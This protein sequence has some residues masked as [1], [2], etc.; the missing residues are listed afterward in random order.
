MNQST[1]RR[2]NQKIADTTSLQIDVYTQHASRQTH[3]EIH[4]QTTQ[5]MCETHTH[6][7]HAQRHGHQSQQS[8]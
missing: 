7:L 3:F 8:R 1:T 6:A 2:T 5:T 4:C